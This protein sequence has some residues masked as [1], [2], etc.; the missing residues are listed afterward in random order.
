MTRKTC[1]AAAIPV[2]EFICHFE[3]SESAREAHEVHVHAGLHEFR[4]TENWTLSLD[5]RSRYD[6]RLVAVQSPHCG[7]AWH[8]EFAR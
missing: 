3:D 6:P 2:A 4:F 8:V 1:E 7:F 5:G